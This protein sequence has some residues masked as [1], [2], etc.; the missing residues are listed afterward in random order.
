MKF[1]KGLLVF[2]LIIVIVGGLGYIGWSVFMPNSHLDL[3]FLGM[4]N[5]S[6]MNTQQNTQ[7]PNSQSPNNNQSSGMPGM[8]Q[9]QNSTN[10]NASSNNNQTSGMSDMPSMQQGQ[11]SANQNNVS[12]NSIAI[13][14]KDKINQAIGTVNQAIDL[15]TIDPYS[16]ITIPS[17]SNQQGSM[18]AQPNQSNGTVNVYPGANSTVNVTPPGNSTTNNTMPPANNNNSGEMADQQNTN[19]VF[20]QGKLQQINTG[21]YTL[22]Q[23]VMLINQLSDDLTIQSSIVE[24]NPPTY[25]TYIS[26]Y[27]IALQNKSKVNNAIMMITQ[28]LTLV[29]VNP[30]ASMNGYQ[31]N[32]PEMQRL[33]Q[34][35]YKLA[36]GMIMLSRLN[37][38]FLTQMSQAAQQAQIISSTIANNTQGMNMNTSGISF[39]LTTIFNIVLI[40]MVI[41]LVLGVFGA[42]LSMFKRNPKNSNENNSSSDPNPV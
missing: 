23:G 28:A 34:G 31:I 11:N 15:I 39:N 12:F 42:I 2:F 26:R 18:Q 22:A 6:G 21:I 38:D 27:N 8:Q 5:I 41:G 3:G 13:Q 35:V 37:D 19:Y 1:L 7:T 25:Q 9:G 32:I 20:D 24:V 14:N 4:G 36:Q 10:Q 16:R 40:V 33:H 29:N 17:K 30:Y